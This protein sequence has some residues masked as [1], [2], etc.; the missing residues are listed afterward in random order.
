M[1]KPLPY[2]PTALP[3]HHLLYYIVN[4]RYRLKDPWT[5]PNLLERLKIDVPAAE[6]EAKRRGI[7]ELVPKRRPAVRHGGTIAFGVDATVDSNGATIRRE[8]P[9]PPRRKRRKPKPAHSRPA[10]ALDDLSA[11]LAA[12]IEQR[13]NGSSS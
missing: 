1:T 13:R 10:E 9:Q 12:S 11:V 3:D 8:F 7:L 4:S 5:H 6:A 2:D